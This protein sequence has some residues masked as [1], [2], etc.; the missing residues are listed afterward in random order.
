MDDWLDDEI[1]WLSGKYTHKK[2]R[3]KRELRA[4]E[5]SW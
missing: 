2:E 4:M 5:G 1:D 3:L